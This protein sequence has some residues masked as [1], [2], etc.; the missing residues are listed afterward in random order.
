VVL[1]LIWLQRQMFRCCCCCRW[2]FKFL[3]LSS[4]SFPLGTPSWSSCAIS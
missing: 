2:H 3:Y 1:H 4:L